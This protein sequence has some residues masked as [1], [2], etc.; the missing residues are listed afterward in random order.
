MAGGGNYRKTSATTGSLAVL[1][2]ASRRPRPRTITAIA[3]SVLLS[4]V[5]VGCS[6]SSSN[7]VTATSTDGA[8]DSPSVAV[9]ETGTETET[10]TAS[11][12]SSG[13]ALQP[14][15]T[16]PVYESSVRSSDVD[17]ID[18]I[19]PADPS[20]FACREY[21]GLRDEEMLVAGSDGDA[22]VS[23]VDAH[24]FAFYFTDGTELEL[25]IAPEVGDEAAATAMAANF[26]GPLGALPTKMRSA[27]PTVKIYGF[28]SGPSSE[29]DGGWFSMGLP[30]VDERLADDDLHET[31]FHESVHM[32]LDAEYADS[33]GWRQ[34]QAD[35]GQFLTD[36]AQE[37]PDREDLAETALF[38]YTYSYHRDRLGPAAEVVAS[39]VP[40]RL[41]FLTSTVFPETEP[42]TYEVGPQH[43]C[44]AA[45]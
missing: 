21:L 6:N 42:L 35:D 24:V 23:R 27:Y 37:L 30:Q 22:G 40:N 11:V 33:P 14:T 5:L 18:Y 41:A 19:T 15:E 34:A 13:G 39:V 43:D 7:G 2:R 17:F 1:A 8:S 9:T 29:P 3:A 44:A 10:A 12:T 16:G 32:S 4:V 26:E 38:A 31:V 20:R 36:Y 45:G 28:D 25:V